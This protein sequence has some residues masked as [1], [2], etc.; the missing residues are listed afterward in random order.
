MTRVSI[1]TVSYNS[2]ATIRSTID[3]V[4]K[5]DHANIEYI[6][7]DA[8]SKDGTAD[9]VR[10]YGDAITQFLS[11]PDQGIYDGMNK[12]IRHATGN[13]I[14]FLNSDDT[15]VAPDTV[16][17]MV[18]LLETKQAD[19]AYADLVMAAADNASRIVRYYDSSKFRPFRLKYGLMPA[20]PTMFVT[21]ETY[22]KIGAYRL[23]YAIAADF[24]MV[25]RIFSQQDLRYTYLPEPVVRMRMG[26]ASTSGPLATLRLN[27]EILRA[28]RENGVSSSAFHLLMKAPI[29][30]LELI[31]P[32]LG[33]E[34]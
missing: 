27:K 31:R 26:G 7:V 16:S 6:V 14:A 9:I 13:V 5:Q 3:S 10:E 19:V 33:T 22:E 21:A 34:Q 29:K 8:A 23:D 30:L 28:C 32:R 11:E 15:Y 2:A 1:V 18:R 12:G 24:E 20:H 17:R 25:V 4:L